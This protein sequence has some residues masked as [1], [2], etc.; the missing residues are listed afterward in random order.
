[1]AGVLLII[2]GLARFG[3]A[4]KFIPHPVVTGF[5]SGI[6]LIIFASQV[7][8]LFGLEMNAVP[9]GFIDKWFA[10]AHA[11]CR[12]SHSS[13]DVP[14]TFDNRILYPGSSGFEVLVGFSVVCIVGDK[15]HI[16]DSQ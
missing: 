5:T 8:D 9:P 10:Y 1:M 16:S 15:P 14:S 11:S 12:L 2:F 13:T 3:A 6:A 4:I 7:R